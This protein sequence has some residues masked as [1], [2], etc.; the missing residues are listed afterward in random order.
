MCLQPSFTR[1]V[2]EE[3]S[4]LVRGL[5]ASY[6]DT[7]AEYE[8]YLLVTSKG[9][10]PVYE[11]VRSF[12]TTSEGISQLL[13]EIK[14]ERLHCSTKHRSSKYMNNI[15]EQDHR[16][17]KRKTKLMLGFK[18]FEAAQK[19]LAGVELVRMIKKGQQRKTRGDIESPAEQF[20]L[21]AV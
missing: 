18:N 19:T 11:A 14:N 10:P 21:L 8:P 17:I 15:I 9:G 20:Y 1:E 13:N 5:G 7:L 16:F 4:K 12:Y 2:T 3:L 6:F